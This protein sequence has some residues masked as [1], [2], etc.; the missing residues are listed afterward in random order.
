SSWGTGTQSAP[1]SITTG[2]EVARPLTDVTGTGVISGSPGVG[3]ALFDNTSTTRVTFNTATP[4]VRYQ[5][6]AAGTT[7]PSTT[8]MLPATAPADKVTF[9]PLPSGVNGGDPKSWV[10]KGSYDGRRWTVIDERSNEKFRWRLQTREFKVAKPGQYTY[11]SLEVTANT[12]GPT[13]SLA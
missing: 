9:Y 8:A 11:Y 4:T 12:G 1:P 10:L 13:T 2:A 3:P 7:S 5:L 6:P